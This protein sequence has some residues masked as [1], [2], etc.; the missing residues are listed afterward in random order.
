MC[1]HLPDWLLGAHR[2]RGQTYPQNGPFACQVDTRRTR[3]QIRCAGDNPMQPPS[4]ALDSLSP[5]AVTQLH[6]HSGI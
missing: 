5:S 1:K 3:C 4:I 2:M 6:T